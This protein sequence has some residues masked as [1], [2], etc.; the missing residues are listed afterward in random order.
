M[1]EAHVEPESPLK[2]N[3]TC[4]APGFGVIDPLNPTK[5][6]IRIKDGETASDIEVDVRKFAISVIGPLMVIDGLPG[7]ENEPNTTFAE[8][9]DRAMVTGNPG[10][11]SD[12]F[13]H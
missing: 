9:C 4:T 1:K 5:E 6:P 12:R 13:S 8:P 2:L 3:V 11:L 7:P 10:R